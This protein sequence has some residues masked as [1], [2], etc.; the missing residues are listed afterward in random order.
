MPNEKQKVVQT[1]SCLF[2]LHRDFIYLFFLMVLFSLKFVLTKMWEHFGLCENTVFFVLINSEN[3]TRTISPPLTSTGSFFFQ[4]TTAPKNSK[5]YSQICVRKRN[6]LTGPISQ[7]WPQELGQYYQK[8]KFKQKAFEWYK[9]LRNPS[10]LS[11]DIPKKRE[12]ALCLIRTSQIYD[13]KS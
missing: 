8:T 2:S 10:K 6:I 12:N 9:R 7:N 4:N 11:E 3:K 5:F 13:T 1:K